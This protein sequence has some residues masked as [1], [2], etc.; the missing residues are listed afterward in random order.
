MKGKK[1]FLALLLPMLLFFCTVNGAAQE[2]MP[3]QFQFEQ[4][5]EE[6][7]DSAYEEYLQKLPSDIRQQV[8]GAGDAQSAVQQY[9]VSYFLSLIKDALGN[10]LLPG[11]KN[12]SVLLGIC[13][14]YTSR[15]V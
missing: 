11:V 4:E 1:F 7:A 10:A 5:P 15:F 14:L 6:A 3:Y 9:S 2:N 13:L 12:L 8:E